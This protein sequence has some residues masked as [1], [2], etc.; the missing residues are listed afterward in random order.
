MTG[1][2]CYERTNITLLRAVKLVLLQVKIQNDHQLT[3][4]EEFILR[5]NALRNVPA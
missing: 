1:E 4:I 3:R 2:A 5:T